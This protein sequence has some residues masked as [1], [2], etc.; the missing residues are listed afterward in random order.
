[1]QDIMK[2]YSEE[3]KIPL[4]QLIFNFDGERLSGGETPAELDME[5]ESCVDVTV[6]APTPKKRGRKKK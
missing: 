4:E 5:S 2:R 3:R 1:M 6:L